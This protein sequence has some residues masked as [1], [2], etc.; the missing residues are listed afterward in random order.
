MVLLHNALI[1]DKLT[2]GQW[3]VAEAMDRWREI[4]EKLFKLSDS[5]DEDSQDL[6]EQLCFIVDESLHDSVAT[7]SLEGYAEA[8]QEIAD[9][10]LPATENLNVQMLIAGELQKLA[11][12]S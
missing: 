6:I 3:T 1:E 2:P 5:L 10:L 7:G 9:V 8:L 11:L 12:P 4:R